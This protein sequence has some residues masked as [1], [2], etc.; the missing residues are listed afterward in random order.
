MLESDRTRNQASSEPLVTAIIPTY[1]SMTGTKNIGKTLE[2]LLDQTYQNVEILVIDN[3]STDGTLEVCK[4]YPISFF[5]LKA[6]RSEARNFGISTMRGDYVLFVDSDHILTRTVVEDC[7]NQALRFG[8]SCAVVP[9]SFVSSRTVRIDCSVMRNVNF[10]L[11]LGRRSF[12]LFFSKTLTKQVT[13]PKSVELYEDTIFASRAI[14]SKSKISKIDSIVYHVEDGSVSNLILRSW[15]YGKK[16]RSTIREIG[17]KD[18]VALTLDL[19]PIGL[20]KLAR[21]VSILSKNPSPLKIGFYFLLYSALKHLSFG[22][23]FYLSLL[24]RAEVDHS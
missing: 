19:S 24:Q 2:S 5:R 23:S 12:M 4:K 17:L 10:E 1:N 3:F 7:V 14:K 9:I 20:R 8:A 6:N 22:I 21:L 16:I 13:F 15:N 11:Q 18:S